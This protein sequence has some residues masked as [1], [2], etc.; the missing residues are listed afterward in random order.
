MITRVVYVFKNFFLNFT[1]G[2]V[3][4]EV[5]VDEPE[6]DFYLARITVSGCTLR[7]VF[8]RTG[9]RE[10]PSE[11]VLVDPG[12]RKERR[13]YCRF[14]VRE[15]HGEPLAASPAKGGV[16]VTCDH[17]QDGAVT[18]SFGVNIIDEV[19]SS[20]S[21]VEEW[22]RE[23]AG[24]KVHPY[25]LGD[26]GDSRGE[27]H[28]DDFYNL[29]CESLNAALGSAGSSVR[30]QRKLPNFNISLTHDVDVLEKNLFSTLRYAAFPLY[31]SVRHLDIS[32][33][34]K[35]IT[36]VRGPRNLNY[37]AEISGAEAMLGF[38][39]TFFLYAGVTKKSLWQKIID[40]GINPLYSI[41]DE[42]LAGTVEAIRA[43]GLEI[44]FHS[45]FSAAYDGELMEKEYA[46]LR[47]TFRKDIIS[48]RNHFLNF[49]IT[50]TPLILEK[51]GIKCDTTF[52]YN[53]R[54]GFLRHETC[55]PFY[56]YSHAEKRILDVIEFPTAVT[57]STLYNYS[58]FSPEQALAHSLAVLEK[59]NGRRGA[60]CINWHNETAAAEYGW[61]ATYREILHWI[62]KNNFSTYTV[63]ELYRILTAEGS[64]VEFSY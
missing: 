63:G 1:A 36:Y 24:E 53:N 42:K 29:F 26:P 48:C 17:G 59:A 47:K 14:S 27:P 60:V 8:A 2:D 58:H 52:H 23:S 57:D 39:S 10:V 7:G 41:S 64:S 45:S 37:I 50:R 16:L 51:I 32:S 18:L 35:I 3:K 15:V 62:K 61:H 13:L 54:S 46:L 22:E 38:R 44:G 25:Y 9:P 19:F 5:T 4:T 28:V 55:S 20:L 34:K 43:A 6:N 30:V 56:I 40:L 49:S 33:F 31:Y 12:D 11:M 21:A